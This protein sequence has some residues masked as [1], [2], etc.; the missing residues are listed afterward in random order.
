MRF[1]FLFIIL[2]GLYG[3]NVH[4]LTVTCTGG[5]TMQSVTLPVQSRSVT[6]SGEGDPSGFTKLSTWDYFRWSGSGAKCNIDGNLSITT[7]TYIK[8]YNNKQPV[9]HNGIWIFP[10]SVNGVGLS[11]KTGLSSPVH[12]T[13]TKDGGPATIHP[14]APVNSYHWTSLGDNPLAAEITLWK[15]PVSSGESEI[16]ASGVLQ[17][18][19]PELY[20]V[21]NIPPGNN[22]A[23]TSSNN[24]ISAYSNSW[25]MQ[26]KTFSGS[27]TVYPGTCNFTHKTVQMGTHDASVTTSAWK[28]ASFTLQ[29]P[30]SYGYNPVYSLNY[31]NAI[32]AASA[33]T[34][35]KGLV[36]TVLPRT[37]E[38]GANRGIIALNSTST[39]QGVGIQLAW[40]PTSQ[41]TGITP[42][43]PVKFKQPV[44]PGAIAA[45]GYT[46]KTYSSTKPTTETIKMSARYIRTATGAEPV[47]GGEANSSIEIL[48]SYN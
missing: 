12:Q 13:G 36:L 27:V 44:D 4:A 31:S 5:S 10:T 20:E 40:G 17:F 43:S 19:G 22:L 35:N 41:S 1:Y 34:P 46:T 3:K 18:D 26:S 29:R 30:K 6:A 28:D 42:V 38:I 7:V 48:A 21:V 32:S 47:S 33:N 9:F 45:T 24:G 15:M 25:L 14:G 37:S 8:P 23:A 11:F 16:P 39:A 2:A